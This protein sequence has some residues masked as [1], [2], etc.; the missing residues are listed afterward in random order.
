LNFKTHYMKSYKMLIISFLINFVYSITYAQIRQD[1][2]DD[3]LKEKVSDY[4]IA[5]LSILILKDGEIDFQ[6]NYGYSN[7]KEK[8]AMPNQAV[9]GIASLTKA[10]TATAI[11]M[12]VDEGKLSWDDPV[13]KY[14]KG[15]A[16]SDDYVAVNLTIEDLL[17]HRSGYDTFDGDL[18]WYGTDYSREEIIRRFSKYPMTYGFRSDYGYQN[19]MFI[20]A[21]EVVE[22]V[23]G[24]SWEAFLQK[25]IFN[26]LG[27]SNTYT[28]IHD[29][30]GNQAVALPHVKGKLD[31]LRDYGNSGGAAA[32]SST[33]TDLS[34]W[35]RF[36][37]NQGIVKEDTLLLPET[38]QNIT[39][40]QTP[41]DPSD[42]DRSNG[43]QFKG[44]GLGWFLMDYQGEKVAHH[45]GGLPGY[46]SK[47]FF[48]PE[49]NLGA[50]ILTNDE[51]S[52]PASLMYQ[53]ID[54]YK[55]QSIR[56]DW[57]DLY[58]NF[59]KS[60][61]QRKEEKRKER[62]KRRQKEDEPFLTAENIRGLYEDP[63]Y[64]LAEV[65]LIQ[66]KL[67]FTMQAAKE[68]FTSKMEHWHLNTYRIKFKDHFLPEGFITFNLNADGEV[69]GLKIDL[70][71]PDFHFHKLDFKKQ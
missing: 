17:A 45:G 51:S 67:H 58:L 42:F 48:V 15:F 63:V 57:A 2:F 4:D 47:I 12:L 64:G 38:Y 26:P 21:G 10:F 39:N 22:E 68:I 34:K 32:L 41:I 44:Y 11:G 53:I 46:I 59:S 33:I 52:L 20:I 9:F 24:Q 50:V 8:I 69:V 28:S 5:G 65:E 1:Q 18:L 31:Q 54:A 23:S 36:W 30:S 60:Y 27:M 66:D 55:N 43:I 29:F 14:I 3:Y 40:L 70:P 19:I 71:N 16:L 7:R 35:L 37:L 13:S 56:K 6:E 61:E 49:M 62:K 25:R